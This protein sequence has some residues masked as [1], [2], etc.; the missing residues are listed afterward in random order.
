MS[1]IFLSHS[2]RNN[3]QALALRD[4]LSTHGWDDL[5]LDL[6]PERGIVAGERWERALHQAASRC[7]AV[8]FLIS[9]AWIDSD[10]CRR[11]FRLAQRLNKQIFGLLIEDLP[12]SALPEEL[13]ADWQLVNLAHGQDHGA[14]IEV[15]LPDGH[16]AFVTFSQGGLTRLRAGLGKAGLD[17]RFFAWPPAGD[18]LRPPYRGLRPLEAE[19]AGIFFGRE[20]PII[21]LLARLRGLREAAPPRLLAILGASGAGKSSF[22]R[23]GVLPR[24]ARDERH[25]LPLPIVRPEQAVLTGSSGLL[26]ALVQACR[27][28]GLSR[29]RKDLQQALGSSATL[30]PLLGELAERAVLPSNPGEAPAGPPTV[31]LAIDQGEELFLAEGADESRAL[32][33]LLAECLRAESPALMLLFTI[34]SDAYER[35]QTAPTLEAIAQQTFS[36]PPL[37][38]GAYQQVIEGP[39]RL[40]APTERP[41]TIDPRLTQQLLQDLDRGGA[42]DALPLLAFTLE[43]L[44]VDYGGD[45][46]LRLDEYQDLGGIEGAI[47]AAVEK[48]LAEAKRDPKVP[49]DRDACL[50]LLRRGLIPWLAGIDPETQAPRRRVARLAEVPEEARPLIHH[51]IEHRLL[52]TD[53]NAQG[54]ATVEPAHEA[55]LRQ[56]SRLRGWLDEDAA[57][58]SVLETLKSAA[59]DWDANGR[60]ADWLVHQAGRLEDA[61]KLA[62]REDLARFLTEAERAYLRECDQAERSRRDRELE[63]ARRL[64]AAQRQVARRTRMGLAASLGLLVV[65]AGAAF[66]AS[67]NARQATLEAGRAE[68]A[69]IKATALKL[70]A[71][72]EAIVVGNRP[73]IQRGLQQLAAA[74]RLDPGSSD[75]VS[76]VGVSLQMT[77]RLR[78]VIETPTVNAMALSP[79]GRHVV[80]GGRDGTLR[81]WEVQTGKPVGKTWTGHTDEI[82]SVAFSPDGRYVAS[83]G[84]DRTLLLWEVQTGQSVGGPWDGHGLLFSRI[85]FSPDGRNLV[86]VDGEGNLHLWDV[87]TGQPVGEPWTRDFGGIAGIA[88]SPDG[89]RVMSGRVMSDRKDQSLRLWE[90][91]TGQP[92]GKTWENTD[93]ISSVAFSPDGRHVVSG[94]ARNLLMSGGNEIL[95]LWDVETGRPVGEPWTGHTD[96][97][98]SVAFS[99]DGR[100]VVSGSGS[101]DRTLR[102]WEMPNGQPVGE[103]LAGHADSIAIVAFS[104]DGRYVVSGSGG[105]DQTLRLWDG[106]ASQAVGAPWAGHADRIGSVAFS[107]DGRYA[108]S[109]GEDRTLRLWEVQTGQPV[110]EPWTEHT[111]ATELAFS[112]DGRHVVSADYEGTLRLWDVQTGQP[113]GEP[114]AGDIGGIA[115]VA[116]S[117]DGR[118]VLSG[119]EGR[120]L[121]LWEV[122]TGKPVGEP[123]AGHGDWISRVAFSPDGRHVVSSGHEEDPALRLWDV[124]TGQPVGEPWTGHN[125]PSDILAFSPDGRYVVS[126]GNDQTL[127]LWEVQTGQPVGKPW[128]GHAARIKSVAFSPDGR[129]VLSGGSDQTLRLWEVQTGQPVGEPWTGHTKS[130]EAVAFSPDGLQML[131]CGQDAIRLWPAPAAWADELCKKLTRNMSQRE[132]DEWVSPDIDYVVQCPQLPDPRAGSSPEES[133]QAPPQ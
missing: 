16:R 21:D 73:G 118:Y 40:L 88:F 56:W 86:S 100:H 131:S 30:L 80:F 36:L 46:D 33:G 67:E 53:Q 112:P 90:V 51:F 132:W 23:A 5:F 72:G 15:I 25:F 97:I 61:E 14:A 55:L 20:A 78:R 74:S 10:W 104:P 28:Q 84:K 39:A 128:A 133:P 124:Q 58:L 8:L 44:Y 107:P 119:G 63:E 24:L 35:L 77:G 87:Q 4:W 62:A 6:D 113:V 31:V 129:Y 34:R 79:D 111:Y 93:W 70:A 83:G 95:R 102:L 37:P 29:T 9:R 130:I 45:G 18:P 27:A 12:I 43:R 103:P 60:E 96:W 11:E 3:A 117:P 7:D 68:R 50:A 115:S 71:Q 120:T 91:L 57:A 98:S 22:L 106:P 101:H 26:Q 59:R 32:L 127:R 94:S 82:Q 109:G 122:Q 110:G 99:H 47:E 13:A 52:A 75:V 126:G 17:P 114:W 76:A 64:A 116:F 42:K 85:A 123:W 41:L 92:A 49:R 1:L 81:L 105:N 121:N 65:A 48:A 19:D 89:R 108:V 2:S 125:E 66:W 38:R 54:E 69:A